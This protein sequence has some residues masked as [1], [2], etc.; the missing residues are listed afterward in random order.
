VKQ[1]LKA[2]KLLAEAGEHPIS[3]PEAWWAAI[4]GSGYRGTLEQLEPAHRE[5]VRQANLEYVLTNRI[6]SVEANV[7]YAI[8]HKR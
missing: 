6:K 4:L 3:G 2:R 8:A 1:A 5:R 7:V